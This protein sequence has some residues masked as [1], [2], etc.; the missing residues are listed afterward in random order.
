[1]GGCYCLT[2]RGTDCFYSYGD[3][4][5]TG[6]V[7]GDGEGSWSLLSAS[8]SIIS[9]LCMSRSSESGLRLMPGRSY[10]HNS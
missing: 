2:N 9:V 6:G 7:E 10:L 1:M 3:S 8:P 5:F 4:I